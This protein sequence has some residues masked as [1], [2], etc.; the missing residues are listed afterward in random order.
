VC[1]SREDAFFKDNGSEGEWRQR[2]G[3]AATCR[4][5][6]SN[7]KDRTK[8]VA[9][10]HPTGLLEYSR[11]WKKPQ[12]HHR[13]DRLTGDTTFCHN[14]LGERRF[15]FVRLEGDGRGKVALA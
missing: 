10:G 6:W 11:M 4:L 8:G 9:I 14:A 3:K 7:S 12:G 2:A 1:H 15:V 13:V 5:K